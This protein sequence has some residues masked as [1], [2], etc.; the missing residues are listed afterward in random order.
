MEH[1][2]IYL[3]PSGRDDRDLLENDKDEAHYDNEI[4]PVIIVFLVL[5]E[6]F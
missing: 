1:G 3:R 6:G 5:F 4:T 2:M